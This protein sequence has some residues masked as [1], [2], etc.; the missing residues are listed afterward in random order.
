MTKKIKYDVTQRTLICWKRTE[1][2]LSPKEKEILLEE[3]K[4]ND[5]PIPWNI[6]LETKLK[7][8]F[9]HYN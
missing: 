4:V 7:K 9:C 5:Q 6:P 8:T 1:M 2:K 3:R